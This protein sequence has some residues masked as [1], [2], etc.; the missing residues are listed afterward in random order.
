MRVSA[1]LFVFVFYLL[2]CLPS[3]QKADVYQTAAGGDRRTE[4]T[5]QIG[6][7]LELASVILLNRSFSEAPSLRAK[8]D[9]GQLQSVSDRLPQ[10]PLVVAPIDEIGQYGGT[11]RRALTGDIVQTAAVNKTLADNLMGYERPMPNSIQH[12]LAEKHCFE[13]EGRVAFFKLRKGVK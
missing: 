2:A 4:S 10:N 1:T 9:V 7:P 11:I 8:V 13:D 6:A 3:D 12:N 5:R